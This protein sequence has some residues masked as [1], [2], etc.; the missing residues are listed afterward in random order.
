MKVQGSFGDTGSR[1]D[2]R[3]CGTAEPQAIED[4]CS[5]ND[6]SLT[7]KSR[8]ILFDVLP[9][10]NVAQAMLPRRFFGSASKGN[11]DEA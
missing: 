7:S 3:E 9:P 2:V 1:G 4:L 8:S 6:D 10:S 5:A 11:A